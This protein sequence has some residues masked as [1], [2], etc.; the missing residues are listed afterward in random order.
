MGKRIDDGHGWILKGLRFVLTALVGVGAG[1][2]GVPLIIGRPLLDSA[3][4]PVRVPAAADLLTLFI[5]GMVLRVCLE[6][7]PLEHLRRMWR[8]IRDRSP[9]PAQKVL[10]LIIPLNLLLLSLPLSWGLTELYRASRRLAHPPDRDKVWTWASDGAGPRRF[11]EEYLREIPVDGRVLLAA[12]EW[13]VPWA[14][15]LAYYLYPRATLMLPSEQ[16]RM[17]LQSTQFHFSTPDPAMVPLPDWQIPSK[18][19]YRSFIAKE[20]IEWVIFCPTGD[21]MDTVLLPAGDAFR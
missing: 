19:D 10:L 13:R 12:D 2:L 9:T 6:E 11:L 18:A 5:T 7:R 21:P 14:H 16:E 1:L 17:I 8:V 20:R 4:A 3:L 15:A